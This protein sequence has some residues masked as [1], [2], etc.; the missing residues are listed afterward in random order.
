MC[1][2]YCPECSVELTLNVKCDQ[3]TTRAV[4]SDDLITSNPDVYPSCGKFLGP[5]MHEGQENDAILIVKLRKGQELR[6]KCFARKVGFLRNL[7]NFFA[8][9]R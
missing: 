6:M 7:H 4:T 3:E 8:G 5:E 1:T 9:I 2:E